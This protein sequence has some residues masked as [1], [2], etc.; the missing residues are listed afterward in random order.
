[1]G[2]QNKRF[3]KVGDMIDLEKIREQVQFE[4]D[5]TKDIEERRKHG[6]FATPFSLASEIVSYGLDLLNTNSV[7]FLEPALGTGSFYSALIHE[8]S[9]TQKAIERA[10]GIEIDPAYYDAA[11][12]IWNTN[13]QIYN[14]D[15]THFRP[16]QN[17]NLLITNPPYV[18]HHYILQE[19]KCYLSESVKHETDI[20]ISGLAGLYCYFLL[21][22]HKWLAQ[23]AVCGW[24]IPSE[25]MD[26]NYGK[27]L[28]EYLL[29][30]VH[31]LR[32]HRYDPDNSKFDD[33]LVSSCVVWFRNEI[34]DYDYDVEFSYG[35]TH[36]APSQ[37]KL[38]KK[39]VLH[40]ERK[41]TR[42]PEK[43][44]R[45]NK[46]KATIGDYFTVKRG[47]ATGDNNFF[48]LEKNKI[49]EFGLDMTFFKPILPSPRYLKTDFVE[50]DDNGNPRIEPQYYL[51][52]CGLTE[53]EIQESYP[54]L[55]EYLQS[56]IIETSNKYLC[57]SR[58]R[59]YWQE[60]RQATHFLCSYM[61]RGNAGGAPIRFI[62][63][64]SDAIVTNSYLMLYPKEGLQKAISNNPDAIFQIWE[65]LK[66]ISAGEI[67][68]EGRIY[69]GG[70]KKIEPKELAKVVCDGLRAVCNI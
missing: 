3:G 18:R 16:D 45:S 4:I 64:L 47:L 10:T 68:D 15:F 70:L 49:L 17:F 53:T 58:K 21:L 67:E 11:K 9:G 12:K 37:R 55:W 39:S 34:I 33:A 51:L 46:H 48:I 22:S 56:G 24:L 54:A 2:T 36:N 19:E 41:W 23:D 31:L 66:A 27:S 57:K 62:L 35:G 69:G 20:E 28:K 32:V 5:A 40:A 6:Q 42:F 1:M 29:N 63:N 7:S 8:T 43:E 61:G 60:Q 14:A 13:L 65:K 50:T 52:D 25:F 30:K 26:V 44:I 38:I 59:W